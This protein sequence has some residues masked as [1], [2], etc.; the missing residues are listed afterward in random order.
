MPFSLLSSY[1]MV[2]SSF[3]FV[4][5]IIPSMCKIVH[6]IKRNIR[7]EYCPEWLRERKNAAL[8]A[9]KMLHRFLIKEQP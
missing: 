5:C 9:L 4:V 2:C 1:L 6:A 8:K 7:G 3:V